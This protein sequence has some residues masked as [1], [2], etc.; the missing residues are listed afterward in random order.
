MQQNTNLIITVEAMITK[1]LIK[2]TIKS[3]NKTDLQFA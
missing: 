2:K 3:E 1:S